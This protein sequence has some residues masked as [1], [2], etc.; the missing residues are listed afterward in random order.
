MAAEPVLPPLLQRALLLATLC[1]AMVIVQAAS[2]VS[3]GPFASLGIHPRD[4]GSLWTI[5]TAPFAHGSFGHLANNLVAFVVLGGL[6]LVRG[7]RH[8]LLSSLVIII[9]GGGL[10][11]LLGR[12]ASHIGASGWIFG[13]WALVIA[14]AWFDRS[15]R[16][17]AISL[18][19]LFA[20]GGMA[21]GVLP[22]ERGVSFESHLFGALAGGLAAW[23]MLRG[24]ATARVAS[25][26]PPSGSPKFWP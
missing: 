23:W 24:Q 16:T 12:S 25:A 21:W 19:V 4:T 26:P 6:A 1:V 11:W 18:V 15:P 10:T 5:A 22:M 17:I 7:L 9:V 20:Y 13:L 14:E 2:W 3:G 8:F